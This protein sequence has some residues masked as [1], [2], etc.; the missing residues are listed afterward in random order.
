MNEICV[1]DRYDSIDM[2]RWHH[3]HDDDHGDNRPRL[4]LSMY[5]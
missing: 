1:Y 5:E 4:Y 2:H 3:Q